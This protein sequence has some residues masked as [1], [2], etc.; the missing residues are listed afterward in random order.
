MND[1]EVRTKTWKSL[2]LTDKASGE[3]P[4]MVATSQV[5]YKP[6]KS[7]RK[8]VY[9]KHG[10]LEDALSEKIPWMTP[11]TVKSLSSAFYRKF[12]RALV[13]L[14]EY[15]KV[16]DYRQM[17]FHPRIVKKQMT[18]LR[19]I[20]F[21]SLAN[22]RSV[23][24][25]GGLDLQEIKGL[26]KLIRPSTMTMLGEWSLESMSEMLDSELA[27]SVIDIGL[28][29]HSGR[30]LTDVLKLLPKLYRIRIVNDYA[31]NIKWEWLLDHVLAN[32]P[33]LSHL[34]IHSKSLNIE[35]YRHIMD[36]LSERRRLD[37]LQLSNI[38]GEN[39]RVDLT[40]MSL[41]ADSIYASVY[42]GKS[43]HLDPKSQES[44]K[45]GII[46]TRTAPEGDTT[47]LRPLSKKNFCP[48]YE[49]IS[50][51][52]ELQS[53]FKKNCSLVQV[54]ILKFDTK[55]HGYSGFLNPDGFYLGYYT[56]KTFDSTFKTYIASG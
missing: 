50:S 35:H 40:D 3:P 56:P 32:L 11:N 15:V 39:L 33:H 34:L 20:D 12:P 23:V 36:R 31:E 1:L 37:Y 25:H 28:V 54:R 16:R 14:D 21:K 13:T 46:W 38:N 43:I 27:K 9:E 49:N 19:N 8:T 22:I 2:Y 4:I 42:D 53:M 24:L 52:S 44:L 45:A 18:A 5:S 6:K 7:V 30:D 51:R 48:K 55:K 26:S 41:N 17:A 10:S 47:P 29:N